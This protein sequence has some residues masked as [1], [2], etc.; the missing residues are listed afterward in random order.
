MSDR[1]KDAMIIIDETYTVASSVGGTTISRPVK[2]MTTLK[3]V[4]TFS[5]YVIP[6]DADVA[7]NGKVEELTK[8]IGSTR[9]C[10]H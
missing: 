6:M 8:C 9:T 3:N 1:F 4:A 2:T 10:L 5:K 7:L